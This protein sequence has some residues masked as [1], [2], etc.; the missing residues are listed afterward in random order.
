[1]SKVEMKLHVK[2]LTFA[3]EKKIY[4]EVL[5]F[6]ALLVYKTSKVWI[7]HCDIHV[8]VET[9][10]GANHAFQYCSDKKSNQIKWFSVSI[11]ITIIWLT[12]ILLGM[13]FL[14]N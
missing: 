2:S 7:S 14:K 12:K 11:I 4:Y 5:N 3:R 9:A 8:W 6:Y 10:H 13:Y 1:M